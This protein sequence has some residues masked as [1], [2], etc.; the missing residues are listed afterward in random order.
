MK[1][2]DHLGNRGRDVR[3]KLKVILEILPERTE[4]DSSGSG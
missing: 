3:I 1:E 2:R 4:L